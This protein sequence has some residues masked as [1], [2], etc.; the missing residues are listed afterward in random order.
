M[1]GAAATVRQYLSCK[2]ICGKKKLK[3]LNFLFPC[4]VPQLLGMPAQKGL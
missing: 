3:Y 4:F 2:R 1:S